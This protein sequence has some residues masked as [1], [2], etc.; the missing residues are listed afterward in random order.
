MPGDAQHGIR[1]LD[2]GEHRRDLVDQLVCSHEY[3]PVIECHGPHTAETA[4]HPGALVAEHRSEFGQP[5]RQVAEAVLRGFVDQDVVRTVARAQY[6][7]IPADLHRREHVVAEV[8]PVPGA[9]VQLAFAE[10]GGEH[11]LIAGVALQLDDELFELPAD[12]GAVG[13]PQ[14]QARAR[15]LVR[16]EQVELTPEPAMVDVVLDLVCCVDLVWCVHRILLEIHQDRCPD[17]TNAPEPVPGRWRSLRL[18]TASVRPPGV[19]PWPSSSTC[20]RSYR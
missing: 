2:H 6:E 1:V 10:H 5:H 3:V 9:L 17:K 12:D 13:Q 8:L 19:L 16:S 15:E 18:A 14:R 4:E 20:S 7:L 11:T